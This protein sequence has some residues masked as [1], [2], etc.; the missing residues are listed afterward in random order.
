MPHVPP[1]SFYLYLIIPITFREDYKP[2]IPIVHFS[3]HVVKLWQE[4]GY[5]SKP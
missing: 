2:L 3:S 4:H 1:I 5:L